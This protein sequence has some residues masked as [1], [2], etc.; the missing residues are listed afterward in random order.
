MQD[1]L[2]IAER[3]GIAVEWV[4]LGRRNGEYEDGVIRVNPGRLAATQ[5]ITLAHELGHAW[6]GHSACQHD[7]RRAAKQERDADAH[8]ALL[9]VDEF[10][11][12]AAERTY[13]ESGVGAVAAE[14]GVPARFVER[15]REV[16]RDGAHGGWPGICDPEP[17]DEKH[18]DD[19]IETARRKVEEVHDAM[20]A[21]IAFEAKW[22][23]DPRAG[24]G[25]KAQAILDTF[26][27][28]ETRHF[29][30][31][32]SALRSPSAWAQHP[33]TCAILRE[34]MQGRSRVR[35]QTA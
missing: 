31:V 14:L 7:V 32:I 23:N 24:D 15:L 19:K 17:P 11:Y 34:R 2:D 12:R 9:L 5:R 6:H 29:Q 21:A 30:R 20:L 35:R 1:M 25:R 10:T 26:G 4:D 33:K 22:L 8:A 18:V 3:R 28:S 27:V 16:E 13:S